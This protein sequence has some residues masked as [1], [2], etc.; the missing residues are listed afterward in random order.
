[1]A[2]NTVSTESHSIKVL[3]DLVADRYPTEVVFSEERPGD[4]PPSIISADRIK[5][6]LGWEAVVPFEQGLDELMGIREAS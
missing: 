1:M 5:H 6:E 3:V 4:A 2:L